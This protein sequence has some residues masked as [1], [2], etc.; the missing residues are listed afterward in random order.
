MSKNGIV[1]L[2]FRGDTMLLILRDNKPTIN[3][4]N[5]WCFPSG[6]VEEGES[7]DDAAC[8]ELYEELHIKVAKPIKIID[9]KFLTISKSVYLHELSTAD[10][11]TI[12]LNEGQKYDFFTLDELLQLPLALLTRTIAEWFGKHFDAA[13]R[14]ARDHQKAD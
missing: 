13:R 3:A 14:Y 9:L 12:I 5:K 7:F 11:D 6:G 10:I 8:R 4:P 1:W 2:L